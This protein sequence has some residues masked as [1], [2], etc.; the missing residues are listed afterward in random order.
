MKLRTAHLPHVNINT[1]RISWNF[2][3]HYK[4]NWPI[5]PLQHK[6]LRSIFTR[7]WLGVGGDGGEGD[8]GNSQQLEHMQCAIVVIPH[9]IP[10]R[11]YGDFYL[12]RNELTRLY[13]HLRAYCLREGSFITWWTRPLTYTKLWDSPSPKAPLLLKDISLSYSL[14]FMYLWNPSTP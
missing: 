1:Q 13:F 3:Y 9:F 14:S 6:K 12:L 7:H 4:G 10:I 11:T 2:Q 8:Q 5:G